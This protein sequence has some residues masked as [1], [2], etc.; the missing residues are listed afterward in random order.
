M[1]VALPLIDNGT[2]TIVAMRR[3]H[4]RQVMRIERQ[5]YPRPWTP[6]VFTSELAGPP[7]SRHYIVGRIG[8]RVAGYG[9]L[10]ATLDAADGS[11]SAHITNIAVDPDRQRSKIGSAV[12]IS[13]IR[14]AQNWECVSLTLEVRYNNVAAQELY[15]RFGFLQEGVRR[16]YYENTDDAYVLWARGLHQPAF[17]ERLRDLEAALPFR[18]VWED[19]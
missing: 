1:M 8:T 12:L 6:A 13:L 9:G 7:D 10:M 15:H 11:R 5:V 16:R 18:T 4:V 14:H 17:K 19:S 3:R 2:V